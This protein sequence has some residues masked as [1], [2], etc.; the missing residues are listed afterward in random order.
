MEVPSA[1][2]SL[3]LSDLP[4]YLW[5]RAVPPLAD[6]VFNRL[7]DLSD[8]VIIDSAA[9]ADPHGDLASLAVLLRERTR[10]A[11]VS[12]LNWARLTTW[13]ALVA[14]FYDVADYRPFL[15]RLDR[16]VIEYAPLAEDREA[17]PPRALL[18]GGWLASRLGWQLDDQNTRRQGIISICEMTINERRDSEKRRGVI[19][20]VPTRQTAV[21][22][23]HIAQRIDL[24]ED[25]GTTEQ[26]HAALI[27]PD[28]TEQ[29]S[30]QRRLA[31]AVGSQ[32]PVHVTRRNR[33]IHT[34]DRNQLAIA[35]H[36]PARL[37]HCRIRTDAHA[38]ATYAAPLK[39]R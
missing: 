2:A 38:A 13:R 9:F 14:A 36:Q 7:A 4:V 19:E 37:Q 24:P 18:L 32:Q 22:P 15:D 20:F 33:Q 35:L 10:G 23:G 5:W 6:R 30:H 26:L 11:A 1:V 31:R 25:P 27:R 8:R 16:M 12:D 17:I 21:E 39:A 34:V 29:H 3:L 28:Q